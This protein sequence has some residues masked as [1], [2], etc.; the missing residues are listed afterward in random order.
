MS[1][2]SLTIRVV[3]DTLSATPVAGVSTR[4]FTDTDIFF[5]EGVTDVNGEV[6]LTVD[7]DLGGS[8]Y[9]IL[10][11]KSGWSIPVG[12]VVVTPSG[13]NEAQY[14]AHQ[15][16]VGSLVD[17]IIKSDEVTPVPLQGVRIRLFS[18]LEVFLSEG[19]TDSLGTLSLV[20]TGAASPV[21]VDYLVRLYKQG[22]TFFGG[23]TQRIKV[24]DP[25]LTGETN[26]FEFQGHTTTLPESLDPRMCLVSGYLRNSSLKPIRSSRIRFF[27]QPYQPLGR[28]GGYPFPGD[29]VVL[30]NLDVLS[31]DEVVVYSDENGYVEVL[32]PR[33]TVM[34]AVVNNLESV[35]WIPENTPQQVHIPDTLSATLADVL[36]P[37]VVS[38]VFTPASLDLTAGTTGEFEILVKDVTGME[39]A[40]KELLKALL[41]LQTTDETKALV[42]FSGNAK[43]QIDVPSDATPGTVGLIVERIEKTWAARRPEIPALV[44]TSPVINIV[45]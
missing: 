13:P 29:V 20:L 21:G 35:G 19:T 27:P 3:D 6:E 33:E 43:I 39:I 31:A 18:D 11:G 1:A 30:D 16:L 32:L 44:Y 28:S 26:I 15:G 38:I 7:A 36:F 42:N 5:T 12:Y 8:A 14:I 24:I 37:Y 10:L 9:R 34:F 22:M 23:P 4:V 25:L 41:D 40:A 2:T 17:L 45:P